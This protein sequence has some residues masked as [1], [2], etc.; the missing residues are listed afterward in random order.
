[1]KKGNYL[2]LKYEMLFFLFYLK[3]KKIVY[4]I[5]FYA[6]IFKYSHSRFGEKQFRLVHLDK[7]SSLLILR[8]RSFELRINNDN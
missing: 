7:Q 8:L 3:L 1:M 5:T 6:H 4:K 2:H